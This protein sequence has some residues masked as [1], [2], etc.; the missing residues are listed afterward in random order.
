MRKFAL[1][2][3]DLEDKITDR[4]NL[5]L[6]TNPQ[7]LG[8]KLNLS[9]LKGETRNTV[10]KIRQE[11]QTVKFTVN[12]YQN[13]YSK[14][15]SLVAWIQKYSRP[16]YTMALEYDDG[17]I[18]RYCEGFV[19]IGE[20]TEMDIFRNLEQ[21]CEFT[22]TSPFFVK[23]DNLIKIQVSS[24]GKTYPYRYPYS[25][26]R[27]L[28]ENNEIDNQYITDVP[29]I[30]T[31]NGAIST[32]SVDGYG[33]VWAVEL[34]DENGDSFTPRE[35]VA[36][37]ENLPEGSSVIINSALGKVYRKNGSSAPFDYINHV[38]GK[39]D[40]FLFAKNG[41]SKI[42]VLN[43]STATGTGFSLTGGWREYRL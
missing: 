37:D 9:T 27:N 10:T 26:G 8:F 17:N 40:T 36:F 32:A 14:A 15:N 31:I 30:I 2:I 42:K 3:F 28:I 29:V 20:K 6:V 11:F 12:Q 7:N 16:E 39:S 35:L 33:N 21:P 25:Y 1:V 24:T 22:Q 4:Y 41:K 43:L 38:S 23:R 13:S 5:D 19:T 18:V 34:V